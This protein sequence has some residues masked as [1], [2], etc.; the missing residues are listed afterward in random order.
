M[1]RRDWVTGQDGERRRKKPTGICFA[2]NGSCCGRVIPCPRVPGTA[3]LP[4]HAATCS[5][6]PVFTNQF[7]N[8][9]R[10]ALRVRADGTDPDLGKRRLAKTQACR[11]AAGGARLRLSLAGG[12][13]GD[14]RAWFA[15]GIRREDRG[16]SGVERQTE[17]GRIG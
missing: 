17:P 1:K 16:F 5:E 3:G 15:A 10:P 2:P 9:S 13:V 11:E 4:W 6:R 12:L 8:A 14:G 7:C